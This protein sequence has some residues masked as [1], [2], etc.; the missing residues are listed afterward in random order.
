[1]TLPVYKWIVML[2]MLTLLPACSL[3]QPHAAS[4]QVRIAQ[5]LQTAN[6]KRLGK[7]TLDVSEVMNLGAYSEKTARAEI[8]QLAKNKAAEMEGDT[9]VPLGPLVDGGQSFYVYRCAHR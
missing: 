8:D 9:L 3:L 7:L 1:M 2:P 4:D 5:N 6:C